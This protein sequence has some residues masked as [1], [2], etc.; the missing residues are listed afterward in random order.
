MGTEQ[1]FSPEIL[2]AV[3]MM[4]TEASRLSMDGIGDV[5][6]ISRDRSVEIYSRDNRALGNLL[7]YI[8]DQLN[9]L[10]VQLAHQSGNFVSDAP[11]DCTMSQLDR[12]TLVPRN[13]EVE[14]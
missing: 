2:G 9:P 1:E 8:D 6:F 5:R 14:V 13:D 11:E 12:Y 10:D 7:E 3:Q 4:F